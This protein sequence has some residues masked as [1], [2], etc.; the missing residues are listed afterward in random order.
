M[1]QTQPPAWTQNP[2]RTRS[3]VR[4]PSGRE[5]G[6]GSV[7]WERCIYHMRRVARSWGEI[8]SL[9]KAP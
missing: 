2:T 4:L 9:G 3:F 5:R 7:A 8:L 1:V 6:V